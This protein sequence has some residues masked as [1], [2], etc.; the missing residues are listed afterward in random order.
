MAS[1]GVGR[2]PSQVLSAGAEAECAFQL[3][4][5]LGSVNAAAAGL[6]PPG[7]RC[8]RR[9]LAMASAC[10]PATPKRSGSAPSPRPA[11]AA[12]DRPPRPWTRCLWSSTRVSSRPE[13]GRR[14]SCIGGPPRGA[15]RHLGR[16]RGGRAEQREPRAEADHARLG[17]HP[18]GRPRSP[19][20]RPTHQRRRPPP[21]RPHQSVR[22]HQPTPS[23][24]GAGD[25]WG[26]AM[27]THPTSSTANR[28]SARPRDTSVREPN[29]KRSP[30]SYATP[31]AASSA[32]ATR[33]VVFKSTAPP[34]RAPAC[35][36]PGNGWP[37]GR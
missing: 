10:P 7:R 14:L 3:A 30:S 35:R 16:Q 31:A 2:Q 11:S 21:R 36:S 22:P 1:S 13:S 33:A 28:G 4:E 12:E 29:S 18:T 8:A 15:V 37:P 5:Q 32:G 19:A 24:R 26:C 9:S 17:R 27:I 20:G 23:T 34:W 25:G 6:G